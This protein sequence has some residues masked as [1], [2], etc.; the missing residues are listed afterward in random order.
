MSAILDAILTSSRL[1]V[2]V[3]EGGVGKTSTAAASAL[4]AATGGRCVAAL[5]IDPAPRL[6]D[7]L[8]LDSLGGTAGRVHDSEIDDGRGELWALK[9]DT[10]GTFDAAVESLAPSA[11]AARVVLGSPIYR[12]VSGSLG[13]SDSYMALQRIHELTDEDL[14]DLIVVDTPPALHADELL[15]APLRLDALMETRATSVLADPAVAVARAGSAL[16]R[17]TAGV[18]V[19]ILQR[20]AGK[21]M[22]EE[23]ARF[24]TSFE[25]VI[26]GLR[27]RATTVDTLLRQDDCAFVQVVRPTATSVSGALELRDSLSAR[28]IET[29]AIVVNRMTPAPG[30]DRAVSRSE[31]LQGAPGG[32]ED[33]VESIEQDLDALR[34]SE[35]A[36]VA[37]LRQ[38]IGDDIAIL[39]IESLEHDVAGVDDLSV[40]ARKLME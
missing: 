36:A 24:I 23:L 27:K 6:G 29:A 38:A 32:V 25:E 31:R 18:L 7:A 20:I 14:Y 15:S 9:L 22:R 34:S 11:E 33:A 37:L 4:A 40:I 8:G 30:A 5:T 16:A 35:R 10:Q 21:G 2:F 28:G 1:V 13:G 39:E 26:D 19:G 3:G 12:A 17:T